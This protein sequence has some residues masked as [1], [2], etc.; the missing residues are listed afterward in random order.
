VRSALRGQA[1]NAVRDQ[2]LPDR[3]AV[4]P[5]RR[6]GRVPVSDRDPAASLRDLRA[7]RGDRVHR[8]AVRR[9]GLCLAAGSARVEVSRR[10]IDPGAGADGPR[11][12][13]LNAEQMLRGEALEG[14]NQPAHLEGAELERYVRERTLTTTLDSAVAW[15]RSNS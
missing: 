1:R 8:A 2:L 11:V 3:D 9:A 15:A 12:R 4:H 14:A 6:R 13:H 5:V 7:G 10:R